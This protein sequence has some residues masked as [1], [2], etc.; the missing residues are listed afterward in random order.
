MT[1]AYYEDDYVTLYHGDCTE[2]VEW[3]SAEVLVTDPPY[4]IG[5]ATSHRPRSHPL[6]AP[7]A[8][9]T[10]TGVRDR[11]IE[12]WGDKPALVFG[13][14]KA[15]RPMSVRQLLVW[16]KG[17]PGMGDLGLPWGPGS[18]EIYVMG[19]GWKG[20]RRSNVVRVP[21][22]SASSGKRPAHPTPKP[23]A[24][25]SELLQC[26]PPGI[27]ADP[28]AGSGSTLRAAKDLGRRAIGVEIYEPYCDLAARVLS[29]EVLPI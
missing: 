14:W 5:Y 10:D 16:D 4:G 11:A 26:C 6:A 25:M 17:D 24:L 18:E 15:P 3:L 12:M 29:Q 2:I 19:D 27:I 9:D 28:F 7:I 20:R 8:N 13:T 23:V 1:A 21:K 22:L